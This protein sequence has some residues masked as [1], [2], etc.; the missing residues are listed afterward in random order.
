MTMSSGARVKRAIPE[1]RISG[2]G[3]SDHPARMTMILIANSIVPM[4]DRAWFQ[5]SGHVLIGRR[6]PRRRAG[7]HSPGLEWQMPQGGID[8]GENPRDAVMRELGK[9]RPHHADYLSGRI[10]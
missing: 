5:R 1:S 4:W 3:P 10:G 9:N 7:D 6:F 2:P 8:A